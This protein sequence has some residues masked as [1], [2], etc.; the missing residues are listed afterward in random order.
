VS[1]KNDAGTTFKDA[2]LKLVAGDVNIITAPAAYPMYEDMAYGKAASSARMSEQNFFE[3]HL[4][5]LS[6]PTTIA[7]GQVKQ[8]ELTA[9]SEVGARKEY[10]FD[11]SASSKVAVKLSFNNT[12]AAGLGIALPAGKVRVYKADSEG[13]LQFLGEDSIDHTPKDEAVKLSIGNAFDIVGEKT[14]T[15]TEY[16]GS[17]TTVNSYRIT[18]R[19]HKDEDVTVSVVEHASGEWEV[20]SENI[21]HAKDSATQLSWKVPVAAD[22]SATLEYTIRQTTC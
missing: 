14:N 18:L 11:A 2:K 15:D 21:V 3:Y 9:A 13:Q 4:Y 16:S 1:L 7:S 22:G 10:V 17:C 6:R 20:T 8:V 5:S 12:Q 19:N